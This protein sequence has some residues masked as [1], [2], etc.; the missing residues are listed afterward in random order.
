M[1]TTKEAALPT[2]ISRTLVVLLAVACGISAASLYYAQPL[3][4]TIAVTFGTSAGT[5]GLIVTSSQIG[6][7]IGLAF[8]VPGGDLFNRR[9][10]VPAAL[11]VSAAALLASAVAPNIAS[12]IALALVVGVG[13]VAAQL[14]VPLAASLA[15]DEARGRVTGTVMSGL[16][17]GILLARTLS[18]LVAGAWGWRTVYWAA[19]ALVA[20]LALA[21]L[22]VL[23]PERD[24]PALS[25]VD[26][27][28]STAS[29]SGK[30]PLLRRRMLLG[31][32]C[33][34]SFSIFW[35]TVAFLLAGAP[36]HYGDT[37]IGL[38]GLVGA[39]G[40]LCASFAG[41]MTDRGKGGIT[42]GAFALTITGSF[43]L[44][45]LGRHSL[46]ALIIGVVVLDIGVQGLHVTNQTLVFRLASEMRSRVNAN[47]MVAYFVGG[48][49]GSAISGAVFAS[50]GWT[51][52][53]VLGAAT[54]GAAT[55]VWI[56]DRLRPLDAPVARPAVR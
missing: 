18:G 6:Y 47:Y 19:F 16:L 43:A 10:L 22:R 46:V 8:V 53:C 24:R 54:G 28:R 38:F 7:A 40:A 41:R 23:P 56:Y 3:L 31:A 25:Y 39:A 15:T 11:V 21:L 9:R 52:V 26:A 50:G 1:S 14:L 12:L 27:M 55:L 29:L 13:S 48:A 49:L 33:F 42:T 20:V 4:A 5:A 36:Y 37:V 51:A 30:E 44:L 45:Y 2:G 32:L 35:T 17:L 34:G